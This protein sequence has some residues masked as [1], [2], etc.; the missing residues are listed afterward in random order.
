MISLTLALLAQATSSTA[1]APA[2]G[3]PSLS[4]LL[5]S[6]EQHNFDRRIS[7]EQQARAA[8]EL[9]QAWSTLFPG[10]SVSAGW[11]HNQYA[12]EIP[13]GTFGPNAI[14]LSPQD[15]VDV[16]FRI[17][18]PL[19][20]TQRWMRISAAETAEQGALER[21]TLGRDQVRRGVAAAWYSYAAAL[22]LRSSAARA[23]KVAEEQLKLQE[24]RARTGAA[25]ELELLRARAEVQ[26]NT[27]SVAEATRLVAITR[28][29]LTTLSG[30]DP[31]EAAALPAVDARPPEPLESLEAGVAELPGVR[32]ATLDVEA[33]DKQAT[34][35]KLALVP[36]VGAQFTERLSN[37]TGFTGEIGAFTLG[38][39][40]A[41]RLDAPTVLAMD[42]QSINV[43]T[44]RVALERAQQAARDQVASDWHTLQA[45]LV[46]VQAVGAQVE[47]AERARKVAATRY[48]VGA[49]T[50]LEVIQADRDLFGAEAQ[51][52][53]AQSELA[54]ARFALRVSAGQPLEE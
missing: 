45:A 33:A 48:E 3:G 8:A 21:A 35:S 40:L 12:S 23:V 43:A 41:W 46:K 26:R 49:S 15:Q 37:A 44:A 24:I 22:A 47:A 42:V 25:T 50:Q 6:A 19:I 54:S 20:D 7:R 39:N 29:S 30:L 9:T 36:T 34:A 5:A 13:A 51:Q 32:A 38:V 27:Q 10:L 18:L 14:T 28:R 52:I 11:T 1:A 2:A 16:A 31:G 53:Q 17:D 4:A